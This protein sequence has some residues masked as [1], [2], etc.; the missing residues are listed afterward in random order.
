MLK[1]QVSILYIEP[2][3]PVFRLSDEVIVHR[4]KNRLDDTS[5]F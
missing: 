4:E 3:V 2:A 5:L 1:P